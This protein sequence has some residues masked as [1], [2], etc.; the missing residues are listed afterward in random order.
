MDDHHAGQFARRLGRLHQ[1]AA[2]LARALGGLIFPIGRLDAWIVLRH[3]LGERVVGAE[4][5]QQRRASEAANGEAGSPLDEAPAV[6]PA[7]GIVI[8]QIE[9]FLIEVRG[10]E[11]VHDGGG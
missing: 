1:V 5:F 6:E 11:A 9:Q 8:V 7:M 4:H 2:H 3:L 10:G